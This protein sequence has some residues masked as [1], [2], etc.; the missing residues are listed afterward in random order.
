MTGEHICEQPERESYWADQEIGCNL[1]RRK[2]DVSKLWN[3]WKEC[4]SFEVLHEP[5]TLNAHRV[6]NYKGEDREHVWERDVG[7]CWELN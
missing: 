3:T 5:L 1:D 7:H 2:Q 6:E 4:Y